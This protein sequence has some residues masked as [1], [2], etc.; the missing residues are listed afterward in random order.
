MITQIKTMAA[1]LKSSLPL[2]I[3][4]YIAFF[5]TI[6]IILLMPNY[7]CTVLIVSVLI[8]LLHQY[9]FIRLYFDFNLLQH[10]PE[11]ANQLP[12]FT[13]ELDQ[14]LTTLKLLS[15]DKQNRD[16]TLRLKGC[17]RLFKIQIML[18]MIQYVLLILSVCTYK[19]TI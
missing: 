9:I 6:L 10:I 13:Q 14:T 19:N 5:F 7:W 2:L 11:E 18:N 12:Q 16:W 4:G 17:L 3:S 8:M 1:L 15:S